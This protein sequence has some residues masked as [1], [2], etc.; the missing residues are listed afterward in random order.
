[1]KWRISSGKRRVL[2]GKKQLCSSIA[3]QPALKQANSSH[4]KSRASV[5]ELLSAATQVQVPEGGTSARLPL[6]KL[7][8][9][10]LHAFRRSILSRHQLYILIKIQGRFSRC[11]SAFLHKRG[12]QWTKCGFSRLRCCDGRGKMVYKG[13]YGKYKNRPV[14]SWNPKQA[15]SLLDRLRRNVF[16]AKK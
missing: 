8:L 6:W 12:V 3:R 1:M 14:R 16:R 11:T 10:S 13:Q 2:G 4:Q 7:R 9:A 15:K 5:Q